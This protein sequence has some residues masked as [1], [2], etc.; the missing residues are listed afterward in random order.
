MLVRLVQLENAKSPMLEMLPGI[1]IF[2]S[3]QAANAE[4]PIFVTL[5]GM[6][7]P[8]RRVYANAEA[9]I[10]A[11][12][13]GIVYVPDLTGGYRRSAVRDLLNKTPFVLL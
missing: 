7:I 13:S 1:V 5:S 11:V 2:A 10:S 3:R 12:P 6:F 9:P 8:V 4:I